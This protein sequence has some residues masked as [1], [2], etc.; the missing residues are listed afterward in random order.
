[1]ATTQPAYTPL[2]AD[3]AAVRQGPASETTRP[4]PPFWQSILFDV[5]DG[6]M[7]EK[8][9]LVMNLCLSQCFLSLVLVTN[10]RRS[11]VLLVLTPFFIAAGVFGYI[12]GRDCA[13]SRPPPPWRT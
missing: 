1:M 13:R 5:D 10:Y 12:G 3:A 6:P 2:D 9:Q 7:L 11:P 8:R 4:P